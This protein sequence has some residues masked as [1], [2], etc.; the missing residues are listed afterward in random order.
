MQ[1]EDTLRVSK[2]RSW[3][4]EP[5]DKNIQELKHE[6]FDELS[7]CFEQVPNVAPDDEMILLY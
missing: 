6:L 3:D 2:L 5:R 1:E 7:L 4:S